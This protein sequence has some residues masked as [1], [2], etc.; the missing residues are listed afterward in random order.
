M[1]IDGVREQGTRR[2]NS[3]ITNLLKDLDIAFSDSDIKSAFRLGPI[4]ENAVRLRSIKVQFTSNA[5]K[6]KI[7]KNIQKLKGKEVWRGVHI[8]DAVTI[9]EQDRRR[10]MRCIYAARRAKGMNIQTKGSSIVIDEFGHKDIL[11]LPKGLS[12]DKVKTVKTKDGIA[13]RSH[14]SYL[15]NMFPC[16]IMLNGTE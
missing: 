5:F 14:H 16:K 11:N 12:I 1:I 8:S 7:F 3:I 4:K 6:Y 9:K 13:F 15:S 2:P 10:D